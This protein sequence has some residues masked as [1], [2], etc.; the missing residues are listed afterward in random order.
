[1]CLS[2]LVTRVQSWIESGRV[3]VNG[4]PVRRVAARTAFGDVVSVTLPD[5]P[6]RV[7][8]AAEDIALSVLYEDD[9]LI[10]LDKPPG[11]VV[12]PT[13]KHAGGTVMNALLGLARGWPRGQRPSIVGRLD[14]LTSGIMLVAKS[15]GAH[16]ALQRTMASRQSEKDYLAVVYGRVNVARGQISA[17]LRLDRDRR[18]MVVAAAGAESL[19][20]FVRLARAKAPACGL[21]VLRCRLVT[22]RRHQ[23]RVHLASRGWPIVGDPKYGEPRWK[24]IVRSRARRH[25]A[26]FSSPGAPLVAA[27]DQTSAVGRD[28]GG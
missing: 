6:V 20:R 7:Q 25:A 15:A 12:H 11:I 22:G 5:A 21:S 18:R 19:T 24:E 8:M 23:I 4:A 3:S 2:P 10:A 26:R 28:P 27:A 16:A 9:Q 1:M 14:M 17:P 13:Y